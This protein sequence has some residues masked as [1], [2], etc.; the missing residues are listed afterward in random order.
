[1]QNSLAFFAN[2]P[3]RVSRRAAANMM[4]FTALFA[5]VVDINSL[6]FIGKSCAKTN[7]CKLYGRS[8]RGERRHGT[9]PASWTA[10]TMKC[11]K[12]I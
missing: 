12:K 3:R 1:M 8:E 7:M 2:R 9:T 5:R 6:V 11:P 4:S 10:T